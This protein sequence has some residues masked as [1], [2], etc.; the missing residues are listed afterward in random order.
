KTF[1][2][3]STKPSLRQQRLHETASYKSKFLRCPACKVDIFQADASFCSECGSPIGTQT[4]SMRGRPSDDERVLFHELNTGWTFILFRK[5][6]HAEGLHNNNTDFTTIDRFRKDN[7]VEL[8][9]SVIANTDNVLKVM[10]YTLSRPWNLQL[11]HSFICLRDTSGKWK[12]CWMRWGAAGR[13]LFGRGRPCIVLGNRDYRDDMEW[14]P[15]T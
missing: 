3:N 6:V 7:V 11:R 4:V 2:L 5:D 8:E 14:S 10:I 13:G 1:T 12:R 9:G 15:G